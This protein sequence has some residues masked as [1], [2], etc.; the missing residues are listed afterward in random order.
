MKVQTNVRSYLYFAA[1]VQ[2]RCTR[3]YAYSAAQRVRLR[4]NRLVIAQ[5]KALVRQHA[6][7]E[8]ESNCSYTATSPV[9]STSLRD[10]FLSR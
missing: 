1:H 5:T 3:V 8:V 6:D 10:D 7:V 4:E 2:R 9:T